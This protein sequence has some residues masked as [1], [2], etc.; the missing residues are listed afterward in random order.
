MTYSAFETSREGGRPIEIYRF[1]QGGATFEYTSAEDEL[2]VNLIT[3][4]PEAITRG[5]IGQSPSDRK[6]VLEITVPSTNTFALRFRPS[7][8]A[9][10][11]RITIQRLQRSDFPSPEVVTIF[12]GYVSSVAF[13]EDGKVAKIACTP[14]TAAQSRPVP[15]FSYQGMCNHV[16]YDDGCKVDDTDAQW[17]LT[18]TA[19]AVDGAV[20]TVSGAG[21][22]GADWWVGGFMEING[23]DD[24]RL[25]LSQS[26]DDLQLLLP[27]PG[28]IT[29]GNVTIFAGCDHLI[30]TC[31]SKF[32]TTEDALSNVINY[33]GFAFVPTKNP[34]QTGL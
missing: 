2:T 30:E 12:D 14:V 9:A 4:L 6:T 21:A 16:L 15:R 34:F 7:V 29:G 25:I 26:G 5:K 18:A 11:A 33:G 31:D 3:Y 24:S 17:R 27:F 13:E 20:V 1:I 28:S 8:P 10:R 23:G 19:T 32:S 22:F